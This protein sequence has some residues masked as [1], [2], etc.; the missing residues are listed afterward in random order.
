MVTDRFE[1]LIATDKSAT[2]RLLF[3]PLVF[4]LRSYLPPGGEDNDWNTSITRQTVNRHNH[5]FLSPSSSSPPSSSTSPTS[6]SYSSSSFSG[7]PHHCHLHLSFLRLCSSRHHV[8]SHPLGNSQLLIAYGFLLLPFIL[9]LTP[10]F[11]SPPISLF[12][13]LFV[14]PPFSLP[15]PSFLPSSS[16]FSPSFSS[17]HSYIRPRSTGMQLRSSG[18]R[19]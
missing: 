12:L 11:F 6:I 7:F 2:D 8:I 14:F 19:L 5:L 3:L 17:P 16:I 9:C 4:F 1:G 13:S 18:T 15:P 10:L